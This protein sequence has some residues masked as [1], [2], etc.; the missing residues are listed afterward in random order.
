M[1]RKNYTTDLSGEEWLILKPL[2]PEEKPGGRHRKWEM[3]EIINAILYIARSGCAWRL[4]PHDFPPWQT[5]YDY[6]RKWR[7]YGLWEKINKNLRERIRTSEGRE[8]SPS[9]GVIDSQSL[10]ITDKGGEHGYDCVKKVNGRKR[11]ILVDTTGLL[12]KVIAHPANIGDREGAYMLLKEIIGKFPRLKLIWADNG[13]RMHKLIAWVKETLG[14]KLEIVARPDTQLKRGVWLPPG[15]PVP[16]IETGFKVLPRRWVVERTLAWIGK[17]RRLSKDYEYLPSM[18]E[19]FVYISMISLMLK[20][21]VKE[22][23]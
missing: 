5:V 4:L 13:Y 21:F 9:A 1:C 22:M 15:A 11:H 7:I 8:A 14:I 2:L 3:R 17:N 20:R 6:F 16:V 10:K 18:S 23:A 19:A 12:M